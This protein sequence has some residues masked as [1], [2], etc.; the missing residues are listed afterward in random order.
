MFALPF[1]EKPVYRDQCASRQHSDQVKWQKVHG[2]YSSTDFQVQIRD[3]NQNT[4]NYQTVA[5][6]LVSAFGVR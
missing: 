6:C 2:I 3:P 1:G 5:E 4:R